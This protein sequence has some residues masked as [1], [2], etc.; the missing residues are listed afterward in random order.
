MLAQLLSILLALNI[1]LPINCG[2]RKDASAIRLTEIGQFGKFRKAR[3]GIPAHFHTGIDIQR[4]RN[5]YDSE[6]IF[7]IATG[8]VI[9][10]RSDGAFAQI[11]I[12][13]NHNGFLFWSLY[14]HVAGI[15]VK[16]GDEVSPPIPIARFMNKSELNRFGWQF[17]HFH[18]E[19]LK[20]PPV[21]IRPTP[22]HPQRFYN[23]YSL[24][25]YTPDDL[26][27]YYFDPLI[28]LKSNI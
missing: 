14:E 12:E 18:L 6:P 28:F 11:I 26:N 22:K 10:I 24:V 19:I 27:A 4:P 20:Y 17:N 21:A 7:P 3:V 15:A 9:S 23:S 16:V 2:N 13:H 8:K 25:C 5:N 1:L